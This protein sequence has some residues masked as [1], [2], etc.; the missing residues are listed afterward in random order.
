[1]DSNIKAYAKDKFYEVFD[2]TETLNR[3]FNW[4]EIDEIK[5]HGYR[6]SKIS[7]NIAKKMGLSKLEIET[8]Q[9]CGL[10]HDIGKFFISPDILN[11]R[12]DL[13]KEEFLI[14]KKHVI[15]SKDY[16]IKKG[17][18]E[19]SDIVLYHHEREDGSGY[20]GLTGDKI[21][22]V[23]KIIAL[24]DVYDALNS[25]RTYRKAYKRETALQ[26]IVQEKLK[27]DKDVY[28]AFND[29]IGFR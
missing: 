4:K 11:K 5:M 3:M 12:T 27:Y 15:Y 24:S 8:A 17:Y 19:Y 28:K 18:H 9:I 26:I 22:L 23:S 21:P 1:M 29:L 6:V 25:N 20:Y 10:L 2:M 13:T 7:S 14:I 16:M